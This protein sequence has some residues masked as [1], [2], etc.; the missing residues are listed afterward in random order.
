[1]SK[2]DK[3]SRRTAIASLAGAASAAAF[4]VHKM[5]MGEEQ[6]NLK[7]KGRIKQSVCRWCYGSIPLEQLCKN[8]KAMGLTA[9]DLLGENE[10]KV[11]QENGLI[12]SMVLG[13]GTIAD[14]WNRLENHN[15]LVKD[16]ERLIPM[17]AKAGFPNLI[18]FSGNRNGM[19]DAEGLRN[20]VTG[21]KRIARIAEDNNV[22]ICC[23]LLNSKRSHP[24]YMCDHTAWGVEMCKQVGSSHVKLLYDIFHMQIMEGDLCDTIKENVQYIAHFHTGGV[25]GRNEIDSSQEINY[26]RVCKA[27][28]DSGFKG[29]VAHEFVPTRDPMTSLREAIRICDV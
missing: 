10:W 25:P 4:G 20:C 18:T 12:C 23:E 22:M 2:P 8:V 14:G 7:L 11:A 9:V 26:A 17:V 6:T 13:I 19:G 24:D 29:F 5:N 27:I 3:I 21:L 1:M 16:A 15:R 28:V